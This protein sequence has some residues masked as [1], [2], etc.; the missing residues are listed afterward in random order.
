MDDDDGSGGERDKDEGR[1]SSGHRDQQSLHFQRNQDEHYYI[2]SMMAESFRSLVL[3]GPTFY[4][5]RGLLG[6]NSQLLQTLKVISF[7]YR[8][9]LLRVT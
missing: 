9:T 6:G 4:L 2:P 7:L 3:F 5:R 8:F 1:N